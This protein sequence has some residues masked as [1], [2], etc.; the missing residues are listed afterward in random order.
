LSDNSGLKKKAP[1]KWTDEMQK[2]I[3][4]N[5]LPYGCRCSCSIS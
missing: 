1:I 4:Q 3:R 2:S 5:A